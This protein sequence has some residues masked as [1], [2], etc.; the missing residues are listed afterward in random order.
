MY[1]Y[2]ALTVIATKARIAIRFQDETSC[3]VQKCTM[4][5]LPPLI[6]NYEDVS[7]IP[8]NQFNQTDYGST[9]LSWTEFKESQPVFQD[10][11]AWINCS[12]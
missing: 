4:G 8:G 3:D 10:E 6:A 11:T 2:L 9:F 7:I 5:F 12:M 1:Y